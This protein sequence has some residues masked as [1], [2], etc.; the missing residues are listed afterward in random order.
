VGF[1]VGGRY[2]S[3]G[4]DETVTTVGGWLTFMEGGGGV[5]AI[6][7]GFSG[8]GGGAVKILRG[9]AVGGGVGFGGTTTLGSIGT[10]GVILFSSGDNSTPPLQPSGKKYR[11]FE[12]FFSSS[13]KFPMNDASL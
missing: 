8:A 11:M 10:G 4:L 6:G 13:L 1:G 9:G 5:G 12:L 3:G 2:L 7:L